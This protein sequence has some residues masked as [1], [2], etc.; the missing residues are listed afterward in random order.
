MADETTTDVT[1][2][3]DEPGNND[4]GTEGTQTQGV[5]KTEDTKTFTQDE[6]NRLV[7]ARLAEQ[8][9]TLKGKHEKDLEAKIAAA[10]EAAQADLDKLVEDRTTARLAEQELAKARTAIVAE[11]GLSEEQAGRLQGE[12]A[13]ALKKD[14]E[15]IYGTLKQ[16]VR[17]KPPIIKAGEG[18]GGADSP[19]DLS[20][21]TPAQ[22][23]EKSKELWPSR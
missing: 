11:L 19:L 16:A 15:A 2:T 1:V 13:E 17:P 3:P 4:T 10:R 23:R 9:R 20:K 5:T 7:Q 14:A 6:V 12:T 18:A 21:M 22:I 8:T